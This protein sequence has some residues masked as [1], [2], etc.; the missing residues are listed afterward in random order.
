MSFSASIDKATVVNNEAYTI[1]TTSST[2]LHSV[3]VYMN[4]QYYDKRVSSFP[5][6][7]SY[8][9]ESGTLF[10]YYVFGANQVATLANVSGQQVLRIHN[11]SGSYIVDFNGGGTAGLGTPYYM[12]G[13]NNYLYILFEG[14]GLEVARYYLLDGTV[15][16]DIS[17]AGTNA[18]TYILSQCR[19]ESKFTFGSNGI[20]YIING[21]FDGIESYS[22]LTMV[23]IDTGYS[24]TL[25]GSDVASS[26]PAIA[27]DSQ[28]YIYLPNVSERKIERIELRYTYGNYNISTA[29]ESYN[30]SELDNLTNIYVDPFDVVYIIQY[31][32]SNST[33][34]RYK[35]VSDYFHLISETLY[36]TNI[37]NAGTIQYSLS[38]QELYISNSTNST[39]YQYSPVFDNSFQ[40]FY[41]PVNI[42]LIGNLANG[43]RFIDLL[44]V[45]QTFIVNNMADSRNPRYQ[46]SGDSSYNNTTTLTNRAEYMKELLFYKNGN[47]ITDT[48]TYINQR[49]TNTYENIAFDNPSNTCGDVYA[50]NNVN[51]VCAGSN[52]NNQLYLINDTLCRNTVNG[53]TPYDIYINKM[54]EIYVLHLSSGNYY[55]AKYDNYLNFISQF[56]VEYNSGTGLIPR[57]IC[58]DKDDNVYVNYDTKLKKY[59]SSGTFLIEVNYGSGS[60][61]GRK[62]NI[63]KTNDSIYISDNSFKGFY[64]YPLSLTSVTQ[65]T[66]V[67]PPVAIYDFDIDIYDNFHIMD[68]NNYYIDYIYKNNGTLFQEMTISNYYGLNDSYKMRIYDHLKIFYISSSRLYL[69]YTQYNGH[70]DGYTYTDISDSETGNVTLTSTIS[71]L[72]GST[73]SASYIYRNHTYNVNTSSTNIAGNK[74]RISLNSVTDNNGNAILPERIVWWKDGTIKKESLREYQKVM[75]INDIE[76]PVAI[77]IDSDNYLYVLN[78]NTYTIDVY[79]TATLTSTNYPIVKSISL[80]DDQETLRDLFVDANKNIYVLFEEDEELNEYILR[81]YD[82]SGNLLLTLGPFDSPNSIYVDN[83]SKIYVTDSGNDEVIRY[84]SSGNELNRFSFSNPRAIAVDSFY[85]IYISNDNDVYKYDFEFNIL[86]DPYLS[87]YDNINDMYMDSSNNLFITDRNANKV[88]KYNSSGVLQLSINSNLES[89]RCTVVD[90]TNNIYIANYDDDSI[91]KY[92]STGTTVLATFKN[93]LVFDDNIAVDGSGNIYTMDNNYVYKYNTS[94]NIIKSYKLSNDGNTHDIICD[95]VNGFLYIAYDDYISGNEKV[96]KLTTNLTYVQEYIIP[97]NSYIELYSLA[98]DNSNN[99]YVSCNDTDSSMIKI[100]NLSSETITNTINLPYDFPQIVVDTSNSNTI[101]ALNIEFGVLNRYR[102]NG[103]SYV[104]TTVFSDLLNKRSIGID[105]DYLYIGTVL[106]RPDEGYSSEEASGN[107]K[108]YKYTLAS[109]SYTETFVYNAYYPISINVYNNNV[110]IL[111]DPNSNYVRILQNNSQNIIKILNSQNYTKFIYADSN[112][113]IY[114][115]NDTDGNNLI[116]YDPSGN[117]LQTFDIL[118]VTALCLDSD[119]NIYVSSERYIYQYDRNPQ[120]YIKIDKYNSSGTLIGTIQNEVS[121]NDEYSYINYP[122]RDTVYSLTCDDTYLY[123]SMELSP[124]IRF[125]KSTLVLDYNYNLTGVVDPK[126]ILYTNSL[127]YISNNDKQVVKYQLTSTNGTF[128][129][130]LNSGQNSEQ[131]GV[132]SSGK[133]YIHINDRI[134]LYQSDMSS[135]Y[136]SII[137]L[138][139]NYIFIGP[140]NKIY[141]TEENGSVTVYNQTISPAY[142]TYYDAT[143]DGTYEIQIYFY[144]HEYDRSYDVTIGPSP[145]PENYI[146]Y[147]QR[148][149]LEMIPYYLYDAVLARNEAQIIN[150]F[151][152]NRP[153]VSK[154]VNFYQKMKNAHENP[155]RLNTPFYYNVNWYAKIRYDETQP[156]IPYLVGY[157]DMYYFYLYF[158]NKTVYLNMFYLLEVAQKY[159]RK[160]LQAQRAINFNQDTSVY[161]NLD[162]SITNNYLLLNFVNS[163]FNVNIYNP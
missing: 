153:I 102:Y 132:D 62:C 10:S 49:Y 37:S 161:Y 83:L 139:S 138:D 35:S 68:N 96:I 142:T 53:I 112:G 120:T 76:E 29:P 7:S 101:Y 40:Y 163:F 125:N 155:R 56:L 154:L 158:Y 81:K 80:Y 44:K 15:T 129:S 126:Y 157:K 140:S 103:S 84:D 100:L 4:N 75:A 106:K 156:T 137:S 115:Q 147:L 124:I 19:A 54:K 143:E 162:P 114:V 97:Y 36:Q 116:K 117:K 11:N 70:F 26:Y 144:D 141:I 1:T 85:N 72:D 122:L 55:V 135:I 41:S 24:Q 98:L 66:L 48:Y 149:D 8:I 86:S 94:Y 31:D 79:N 118:F 88:D 45:T 95:R 123:V 136:S 38:N 74:N 47:L 28:N 108:V 91:L 146:E 104:E 17:T 151:K 87:G 61:V 32:G 18:C 111:E 60:V 69:T 39:I 121:I 13:Y 127:M 130:A 105:A 134:L 21:I 92:D 89:P 30:L 150:L 160:L 5:S 152:Q 133:I 58:L 71:F 93:N 63:D 113:N 16:R 23:N 107:N 51:I 42:T 43:S 82:P 159:Y 27:M 65:I 9:I 52:V 110:Y 109:D 6:N 77:A 128:I 131:F 14:E 64:Q 119:N 78:E 33:I 148:I 67:S 57:N 73:K 25:L 50:L 59:N 12:T 46:I 22:T 90:S 145:E 3:D 20:C 2:T 99:L 34:K